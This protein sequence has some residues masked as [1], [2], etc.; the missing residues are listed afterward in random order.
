MD[1]TEAERFI[2]S[3]MNAGDEE[4]DRSL[5]PKS[6]GDYVGQEQVK[7]NLKVFIESSKK[8]GDSLDHVLLY[9]PPGLGK[10][11]LSHIIANELGVQ[12]K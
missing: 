9:G 5:R 11:T 3:S 8:R 6:I 1:N 2:S 4:L 7:A 10:T 12:I